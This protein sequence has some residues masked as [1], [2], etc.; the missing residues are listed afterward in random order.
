MT[1]EQYVVTRLKGT[2]PAFSGRYSRGHYRGTFLC[3]CCGAELFDA[4]HK[5]ESGT[6]W[7]S[8]WRPINER[9]VGYAVDNSDGEASNRSHVPPL[10]RPSRARLRRR[11]S[12]DWPSLL[13]EFRRTQA[14]AARRSKSKR[15]RQK[16]EQDQGKGENDAQGKGQGQTI[17]P[18]KKADGNAL[19]EARNRRITR[20]QASLTRARESARPPLI[21]SFPPAVA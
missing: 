15:A 5:Y 1:H 7:P 12:A 11:S 20:Q 19:R 17:S 18:A 10:R 14:S 4:E 21:N 6:G 8:F 13:H 2:E 16:Q 9:A 3:V